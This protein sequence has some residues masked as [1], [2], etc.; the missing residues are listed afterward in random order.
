MDSARLRTSA[1]FPDLVGMDGLQPAEAIKRLV[2]FLRA[3]KSAADIRDREFSAW[4][5]QLLVPEAGLTLSDN[6]T[7]DVSTARHGFAPKAPDNAR[8]FLD[9]TG[10]WSS[11]LVD[12][13]DPSAVDFDLTYLQTSP[14]ATDGN[15]YDLDLSSIVPAGANFVFVRT[16]LVDN[17][18]SRGTL[19]L[20]KNGNSN[21]INSFRAATQDQ[22]DSF[23]GFGMV[24]CDANRVI[25][26]N[27]T[28]ITWSTLNIII[29]GWA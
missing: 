21:T 13:G 14:R 18:A 2:S 5:N 28:N 4:M 15:W 22:G 19:M 17:D 1:Q 16:A 25:E 7:G 9:G 23:Q 6:T 11:V 12:R 26:F 27:A 20:R 8:K 24:A 10:A 3:F 29:I